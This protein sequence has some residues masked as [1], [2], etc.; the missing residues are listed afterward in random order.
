MASCAWSCGDGRFYCSSMGDC[1]HK[2]FMVQLPYEQ[3]DFI[4][5][6]VVEWRDKLRHMKYE[7]P[8]RQKFYINQH[9]GLVVYNPDEVV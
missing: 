6:L 3:L 9:F 8:L 5:N 2:E 7:N 1:K 4:L